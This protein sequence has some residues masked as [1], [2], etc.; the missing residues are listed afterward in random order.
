MVKVLKVSRF[1]YLLADGRK[2]FSEEILDVLFRE[3]GFDWMG[4][5]MLENID[6]LLQYG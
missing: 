3:N 1:E 5:N 4:M 6:Y 2:Y